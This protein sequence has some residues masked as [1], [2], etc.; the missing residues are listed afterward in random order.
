[1]TIEN[2]PD[3]VTAGNI[4]RLTGESLTTAQTNRIQ[5][6]L[7]EWARDEAEGFLD[8]QPFREWLRDYDPQ[9]MYTLAEAC[10]LVYWRA[11][12]GT[13]R[14]V[15]RTDLSMARERARDALIAAYVYH[16]ANTFDADD[17]A[18]AEREVMGDA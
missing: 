7:E 4:D 17:R 15:D 11:P 2:Y 3:G 18:E 12:D 5:A 1:M 10:A 14:Q 9:E 13:L 8:Q 6:L 16:R